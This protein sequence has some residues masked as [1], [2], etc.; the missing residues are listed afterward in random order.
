MVESFGGRILESTTLEAVARRRRL[1]FDLGHAEVG[2]FNH[3]NAVDNY[4]KNIGIFKVSV[5]HLIKS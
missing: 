2:N 5:L 3:R 4:K 1:T